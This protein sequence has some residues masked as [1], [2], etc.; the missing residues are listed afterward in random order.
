MF[1]TDTV[2]FEDFGPDDIGSN[3]DFGFGALAAGETF[4]FTIY[5]GALDTEAGALAALGEVSAELFSLGQAASDPLGTGVTDGSTFLPAGTVTP[6]FIFGFNGVGGT[7]IIPD[8]TP[9]P[10]PDPNPSP[11]PVPASALLILSGLGG[12]GLMRRRKSKMAS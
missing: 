3:F 6:T 2:D 12:L 4:D 9:D 11:V 1:E 10:I 5:Y 8:P 7:I